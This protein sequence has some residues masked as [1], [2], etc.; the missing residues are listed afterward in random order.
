PSASMQYSMVL[1]TMRIYALERTHAAPRVEAH[2]PYLDRRLVEFALAIPLEQKV[3]PT[4]TRSVVRRA[5]R[6]IMPDRVR[7]RES[8]SGPTE[9]FQRAIIREWPHLSAL[10]SSSRAAELGY[11]DAPAF[12]QA[13]SRVRHGLVVNPAQM[14]RTIS[15]ELWLRTLETGS[16]QDEAE[17]DAPAGGTEPWSAAAEPQLQPA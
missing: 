3:R 11:I 12:V 9:A 2:Y 5:F 7:Q 17:Q 16:A 15:L 13:L 14:H 10:F 4:E 8:K 6:D 1:Q